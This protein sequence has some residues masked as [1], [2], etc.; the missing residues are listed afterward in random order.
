LS[1]LNRLEVIRLCSFGWDFPTGGEILGVLGQNDPQKVKIEK[2][3]C[4][5]GTFLRQAA[6]VEPLCE[7][8]SL[9]VWSLQERK[10]KRKEGNEEGREVT[11]SVYVTYAWSDL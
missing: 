1:I 9:A 4:W 6:S 8:L 7:K 3:T 5:E 10:K 11:R 2:S